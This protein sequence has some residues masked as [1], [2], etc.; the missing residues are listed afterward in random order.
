[1][2]RYLLE[3]ITAGVEGDGWVDVTDWDFDFEAALPHP[4]TFSR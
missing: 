1:M 2:C 4:G 3:N